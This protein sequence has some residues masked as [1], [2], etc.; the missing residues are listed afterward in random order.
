[1]FLSTQGVKIVITNVVIINKKGGSKLEFHERLR[2][3]VEEKG[4]THAQ[5]A[6]ML[7]ISRPTA[8]QYL[9]GHHPPPMDTLR[10]IARITGY[11]VDYL[12]DGDKPKSVPVQAEIVLTHA[13]GRV[14]RVPLSPEAQALIEFGRK[15]ARARRKKKEVE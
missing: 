13:D 1:M 14:D 8:T 7:N 5:F 4:W 10:K 2:A 15:T 9:N 6:T 3:I 12:L 11:S